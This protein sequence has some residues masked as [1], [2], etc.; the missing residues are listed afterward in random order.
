MLSSLVLAEEVSLLCHDLKFLPGGKSLEW[1]L[2][3]QGKEISQIMLAAKNTK[4]EDSLWNR[5]SI[6]IF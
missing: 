2:R 3:R 5:S 6:L 4:R 1:E